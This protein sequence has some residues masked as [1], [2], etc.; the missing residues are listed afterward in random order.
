MA[1]NDKMH[2]PVILCE[3]AHAMG[4][5][6]GG[7]EDY[8]ALFHDEN[9]PR[10]QGGFIWDFVDQGICLKGASG[11][12]EGFGY[13]GDFGDYPNTRQFCCNGILGPDRKPHP[14]AFQAKALQCPI[15][16]KLEHLASRCSD[17][18]S[19]SLIIKNRRSF[20]DTSDVIFSIRLCCDAP[21]FKNDKGFQLK[22]SIPPLAS[23][24]FPLSRVFQISPQ[25][26][27]FP[28]DISD[29]LSTILN[30]SMVDLSF[31][32]EIWLDIAVVVAPGRGS[33]FGF[34]ENEEMLRVTLK[35]NIFLDAIH[36]LR[37]KSLPSKINMPLS[38]TTVSGRLNHD[39]DVVIEWSDGS[40]ANVSKLCGRLTKWTSVES[41]EL[42]T[43]PLDVCLYRA[44]TDNDMGGAVFSYASRWIGAG[45][46]NLQRTDINMELISKSD[47]DVVEVILDCNL[48]PGADVVLQYSM[49]LRISYQFLPGGA[50]LVRHRLI[51]CPK[52]PPLPRVGI[53][54]AVPSSTERVNW[55]G[56]GPHEAYEDR[57]ACVTLDYYSSTVRDL[58]VPYVVP[59]ESGRRADPRYVSLNYRM[60]N[61][62]NCLYNLFISINISKR[63]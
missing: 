8:W 22:S 50:V 40:V 30:L 51:P 57:K 16:I 34:R 41:G 46:D 53:R 15:K 58:H 27:T 1:Q 9:I 60:M 26:E 23:E 10:A 17:L 12:V 49:S 54:F 11:D 62:L 25:N 14:I 21:H 52:L 44:P 56:L 24:E 35:D 36:N 61:T 45:L 43:S 13:G 7:L 48:Q 32:T 31:A 6:S 2:R 28:T 19:I 37:S 3:Y 55:F 38:S 39:G 63:T 18:N 42:I 20:T 59:Q 47:L 33:I 5:S 4:N 29:Q